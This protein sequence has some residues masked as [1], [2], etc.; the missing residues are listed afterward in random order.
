MLF[1]VT[2][3]DAGL[4]ICSVLSNSTEPET[5]QEYVYAHL[6]VRTK[7]GD[8]ADTFDVLTAC[9]SFVQRMHGH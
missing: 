2:S 8:K 4:Y 1:D 9:L 5:Y 3:D 7:P 6:R